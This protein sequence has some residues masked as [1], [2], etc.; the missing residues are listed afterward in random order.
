MSLIDILKTNGFFSCID[1]KKHESEAEQLPKWFSFVDVIER[2][3]WIERVWYFVYR[4]YWKKKH[5]MIDIQ[6]KVRYY[7]KATYKHTL[8]LLAD[9]R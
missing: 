2:V 8:Q 1:L 9:Q 7:K 3:L 4:R 6:G 5:V